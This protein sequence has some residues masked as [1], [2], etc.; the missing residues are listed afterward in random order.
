MPRLAGKAAVSAARTGAA[1]AAAPGASEV[2][3]VP[4]PTAHRRGEDRHGKSV[5]ELW[6]HTGASYREQLQAR[7]QETM[8]RT[9]TSKRDL[10]AKAQ[11]AAKPRVESPTA[12]TTWASSET[13]S[14][15][16]GSAP[17]GSPRRSRRGS[18]Q[19]RRSLHEQEQK[20]SAWAQGCVDS[21]FDDA[22]LAACGA[23]GLCLYGMGYS[24]TQQEVSPAWGACGSWGWAGQSDDLASSES[25]SALLATTP[26]LSDDVCAH[27]RAEAAILTMMPELSSFSTEQIKELLHTAEPCA[28]ED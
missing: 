11:A 19:L 14:S 7:G 1:K 13:L 28:Y 12:S 10:R 21:A 16:S 17:G 2:Q 20:A 8:Q 15:S 26:V 24:S 4:A 22:D 6:V 18:A 5:A 25:G 27:Q 23:G 9:R 3:R